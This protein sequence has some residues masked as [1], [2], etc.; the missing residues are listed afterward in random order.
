M[1]MEIWRTNTI[2]QQHDD[3]ISM[4]SYYSIAA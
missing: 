1:M 3:M 2:Q 4:S